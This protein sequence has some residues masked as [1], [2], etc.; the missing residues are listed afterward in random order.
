MRHESFGHIIAANGARDVAT[1]MIRLPDSV[2]WVA[3]RAT[4]QLIV[5]QKCRERKLADKNVTIGSSDVSLARKI[6]DLGAHRTWRLFCWLRHGRFDARAPEKSR[7][8]LAG[9]PRESRHSRRPSLP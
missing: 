5:L 9:C 1:Q 2:G 8:A 3:P 7:R 4:P 6:F